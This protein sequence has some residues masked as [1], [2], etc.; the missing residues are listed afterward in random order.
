MHWGALGDSL[1]ICNLQD[2]QNLI[3]EIRLR[4][5][6]K[7]EIAKHRVEL[8]PDDGRTEGR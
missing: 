7:I 4:V 8:D 2:R 5:C 1:G 6:N 3:K